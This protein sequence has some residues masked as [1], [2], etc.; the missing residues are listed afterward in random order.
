MRIYRRIVKINPYQFSGYTVQFGTNR[1]I[2]IHTFCYFLYMDHG[3]TSY[4]HATGFN[5]FE[6]IFFLISRPPIN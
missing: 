1:Y 2:D 5:N 3:N 4:Y 6:T